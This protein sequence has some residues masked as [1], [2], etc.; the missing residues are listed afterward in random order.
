MRVRRVLLLLTVLIGMEAHAGDFA[1]LTFETTDGTKASV[2]VE[3]LSISFS[4]KTLHTGDLSFEVTN[5]KQMYFS[6]EDESTDMRL[7]PCDAMDEQADIYDLKGRKITQKQMKGG[8][9][10]LVRA[11]GSTYKMMV[12]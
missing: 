5:L 10:Y 11:K 9:V 6:A 2:S 1:Y 12:R 8:G 7:V 3:G 4:G